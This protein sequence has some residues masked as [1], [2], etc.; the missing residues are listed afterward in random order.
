MVLKNLHIIGQHEAMDL[1]IIGNRIDAIHAFIP[2]P[3]NNETE[4]TFENVIAFPGLINSHDHLDFDLFSQTGNRIYKSYVDWGADIQVQNRTDID[5][6]LRIPKELRIE[7]GM[8]KNLLNG[9]TVVVNHG[10]QIHINNPLINVFQNCYSLHSTDREKYWKVKLNNPFAKKQP[11]V[12]HI[13]EGTDKKSFRE[14]DTLIGWNLFV[15]KLVA[16]HGVAMNPVQALA[17]EALIWCPTSN[18]FLLNATAKIDVLKKNIPVIF[19]TDSTLTATWNTW[20]QLRQ[21]RATMLTS[22]TELFEMLTTNPARIFG[23]S[24]TA[25]LA[26]GKAATIVVARS[27]AGSNHWDR[28]YR[29]N[30][31]DILLVLHEGDTKLFDVAL[32]DQLKN[33]IH[34]GEFSKIAINGVGKYVKG[35]L[36]GLMDK[37]RHYHAT[38]KFPVEKM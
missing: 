28:F 26:K 34:S 9:I 33:S 38:V 16:V 25:E 6:V 1:R 35:D 36:P 30:P 27:K 13:G 8:Y 18:F 4:I 23:M 21:A 10:E 12:I 15:R 32:F 14:I 22:D 11:F 24:N 7:W 2:S 19:G 3:D 31:E 20:D 29:L 37:I 17:F 5:S